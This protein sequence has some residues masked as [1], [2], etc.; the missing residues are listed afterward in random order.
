MRF[1]PMLCAMALLVSACGEKPQEK[2]EKEEEFAPIETWGY[3]CNPDNV[4]SWENFAEGWI[5]R[6]CVPCHSVEL[7]EG[8][9]ADAPLGVDFNSY[10]MVRQW[11]DNMFLR[12]AFDHDTMPPA[13]GPYPEDRILFGEWLVCQAPR[14]ADMDQD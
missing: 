11:A 2:E 5:T 12:A 6:Q 9:R 4:V 1:L 10:E 8:E 3:T 7:P 13:G 14:E